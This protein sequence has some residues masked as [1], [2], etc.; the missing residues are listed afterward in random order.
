MDNHKRDHWRRENADLPW[1]SDTDLVQVRKELEFLQ[2]HRS[3]A[4]SDRSRRYYQDVLWFRLDVLRKYK[5]HEFCVL[6]ISN[7]FNGL[8][9]FLDL[10]KRHTISSTSFEIHSG[11]IIMMR[12]DDF[13]GI[14]PR[15]RKYHWQK[16]QIADN[17]RS[18]R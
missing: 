14:P 3:S 18:Y 5:N 15:E 12:I 4:A 11:S 6:N 16:Y 9:V 7:P 13:I 2:Q 1:F 17:V 8:L 10:D